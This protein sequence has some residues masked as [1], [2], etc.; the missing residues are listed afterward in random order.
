MELIWI[1][2]VSALVSFLVGSVWYSIFSKLWVAAHKLSPQTMKYEPKMALLSFSA[3]F[4]LHFFAGTAL[5]VRPPFEGRVGVG[6]TTS[7][8]GLTTHALLVF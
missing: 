6:L 4:I 7:L 8:V 2:L 5:T 3:F 1:S